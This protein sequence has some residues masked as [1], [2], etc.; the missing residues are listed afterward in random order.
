[1]TRFILKC[2]I[3]VVAALAAGSFVMDSS[4]RKVTTRIKAPVAPKGEK[5]R[6]FKISTKSPGFEE[7]SKNLT[8]LGY[9][10]KTSSSKETFFVENKS[11]VSLSGLELQITYYNSNKKQIHRRKVDIDQ[12][13]PAHE[14]QKVDIPSWDTQHSFHYINSTPTGKKS[15]PYTISFKILSFREE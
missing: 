3:V 13:F 7:V 15:A 8:F 9:D 5:G 1:M 10:K 2:L 6:K 4:A 14:T 12:K 11:D